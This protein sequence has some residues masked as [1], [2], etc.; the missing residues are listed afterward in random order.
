MSA[1]AQRITTP[2]FVVTRRCSSDWTTFTATTRPFAYF[3]LVVRTPFDPRRVFLY[4][5]VVVR[6][7]YPLERTVS[8]SA[9]GLVD[10][11][12]E[13][14]SSPVRTRIPATPAA[15]RPLGPASSL[16]NRLGKPSAGL[17]R[18]G[19]DWHIR[20]RRRG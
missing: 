9:S 1:T 17:R 3:A 18:L 10:R 2:A 15:G 11:A 16:W 14:T 20:R 8:N 5:E 6:C 4:S 12:I 7:P 13:T 19:T